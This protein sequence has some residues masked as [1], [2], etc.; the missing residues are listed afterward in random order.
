MNWFFKISFYETSQITYTLS[1][2][3]GVIIMKK[4]LILLLAAVILFSGCLTQT[5]VK[6]GPVKTGD[7]IS[8]DYTGSLPDGKV[9]DTSIEKV[10]IENNLFT[11]GRVY[12]PLNFTVGK[13]EVIPGLDKD[14]MGMKVGETKV[15]IIPPEEAYG[16]INPMMIQTYPIIQVVPTSFHRVVEL[17]IDQFDGTFG[18]GHKVGDIVTIPNT[19][20]NLTIQNITKNVS[21]SYNFKVGEQIPSNAPWNETVVK[22]DDK[23]VTVNYSVKMNDLIQFPNVPWNTTVIGISNVNITLRH[24]SIPDTSMQTM[25]G[26]IKVSFNETSI[27]MDQNPEYA[28]QTLIFNVTLKSIQ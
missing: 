10:A 15:F 7:N 22:V 8:I 4:F 16:Q 11:Q 21:L 20:I 19:K 5:T 18:P 27:I 13:G 12:K 6:T 24:N 26:R 23:N 9:F 28:G 1:S 17:P 2:C 3:K 14:V 25:F